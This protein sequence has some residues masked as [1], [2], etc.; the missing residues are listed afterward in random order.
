MRVVNYPAVGAGWKPES[1]KAPRPILIFA[2]LATLVLALARGRGYRTERA[3]LIGLIPL[4]WAGRE[5]E[6]EWT[7]TESKVE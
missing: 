3:P 6:R 1:K 4:E 7:G 5:R 2:R